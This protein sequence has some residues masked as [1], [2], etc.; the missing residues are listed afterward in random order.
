[1]SYE[2][3][4]HGVRRFFRIDVQTVAR[5]SA[6]SDDELATFLEARIEDFVGRGMAPTDARVEA[7]RRLG[8]GG[9]DDARDKLRQSAIVREHKVRLR[10]RLAD[11]RADLVI[12]VRTLWHDRGYSLVVAI[13]LS[14][15]I[16]SSSATFAA[17]HHV[18]LEPLPVRDQG[19]LAVLTVENAALMDKH[20]GITY[21][22]IAELQSRSH[23]IAA[24]AGV[25][26]A[27]AAAP[28]AAR[29]GDR[30]V[31]L[32]LTTTTG[33]FF[34]VL[35]TVP[36]RGRFFE[37]ADDQLTG[38][39][40][41]VLSYSAWR[42]VFGS[43][44]D[45]IGHEVTF[46]VG[47]FTIIG[48]APEEFDY[49]RGTDIW[50]SEA[51]FMRLAGYPVKLDDGYWDALVRLEAPRGIEEAKREMTASVEQSTA[52]L[53][54]PR[55]TRSVLA[56][57]FSE[58]VVGNQRDALIL[59]A[60]AVSLV[61]VVA[62]TNV[63]GLLL[64]RGLARAREVA[65]RKALGATTR[66]IVRQL[67][68]ENLVLSAIG[69]ALGIACAR[70]LLAALIGLAPPELAR[71]DRVRLDP[72]V[73]VFAIVLTLL[74]TL[75]FGLA[76]ALSAA[77]STL[78]A[79]LQSENRSQ[80]ASSSTVRARQWLVICQVALAL[81]ML[82]S[83]GLLVRNLARLQRLALGFDPSHLLFVFVEQ[84]DVANGADANAGE[85]RHAAVIEGLVDRLKS[86]PRIE[87]AAAV[88]AIPFSV[89][90][91]TGGL[92]VHFVLQ[93]QPF[94]AGMS[95]T[96]AG[97]NVAS[98]DYFATLRI[99]IVQGRAFT[100]DDRTG[101]QQV[102][103]VSEG[104]ANRAWHGRNPIGQQ[105]RF[106]NEGAVGLWRTVVGI[107]ADT[108]YHDFYSERPE[109]YIPLYQSA[110]GTF[111]AVR[112]KGDPQEV[113]PLARNALRVLDQGYGI[114]KAISAEQLLQRR[115]ARPRFLA[116]TISVLAAT[117]AV[118]AAV[119]LFGVLSF[120]IG[121]RR[122]EFGIRLAHGAT[123]A[124]LRS[125]V[126][127]SVVR[128]TVIGAALG[129]ALGIPA[130]EILRHEIVGISSFDSLSLTA[131]LLVLCT[132]VILAAALPVARAA[133]VDPVSAIRE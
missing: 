76:P 13:T 64:A 80:S 95:S 105:L 19:K 124:H 131:A 67:M 96:M 68:I 32:A 53:L 100:L 71:M 7:I 91:G 21:R 24:I 25:P 1:V 113:V 23:A 41:A 79:P 55:G 86:T 39:P 84:L 59:F 118:L 112:S 15:G 18:L 85:A 115:L 26:A 125:L 42:R 17:F 4:R 93:G 56:Q 37:A 102:A 52:P 51:A 98:K 58:V 99:P 57:S 117:V 69:G 104:F 75:A 122:R 123:A 92:Q 89:V 73:A 30:V 74:T 109:V 132:I 12:A 2:G 49:P 101:S 34:Q 8:G 90:A 50:V 65:V 87:N 6:D 27:L 114:A 120:S 16:G 33:N 47:G 22:L 103:I 5:A 11:L 133:N 121:Q 82:T 78:A 10:E 9:L 36:Q 62:C 48:V 126:F 40:V 45:I 119:G 129:F 107:A 43:R 35:G 63:A 54:G 127:H 110:P 14:L 116:A 94:S 20:V 88:D 3:V 72:T 29:D 44:P 130:A 46:N 77:R 61:L 60:A 66:R 111:I 28:Y 81:V 108:K 106:L 83:A 97:F 70:L 38:G 128:L 31:Q